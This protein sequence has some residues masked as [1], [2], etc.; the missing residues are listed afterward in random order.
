[1]M[2]RD[3]LAKAVKLLKEGKLIVFPTETVYALAG[4]ARNIT[5]IQ[6]IFELTK[7]RLNQPLSVLLAKEHSLNEWGCDLL[8]LAE[9]LAA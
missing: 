2:N 5:A 4:D 1:M 3:E 9:K 6:H 7:R 8:P